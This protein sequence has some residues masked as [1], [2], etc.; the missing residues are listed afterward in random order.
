MQTNDDERDLN[1]ATVFDWITRRWWDKD[2]HKLLDENGG[3]LSFV[4]AA[5]KDEKL[6]KRKMSTQIDVLEDKYLEW[7]ESPIEVFD[8]EDP[9]EFVIYFRHGYGRTMS[10]PTQDVHE[11]EFIL[12]YRVVDGKL[13]HIDEYFN[14]LELFRTLG[15]DLGSVRLMR[16]ESLPEPP[17][18]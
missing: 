1:R 15:S 3:S 12:L 2:Q 17:F 8:T 11:S 9:C 5:E 7:V 6:K 13:Q 10:S 4:F 16:D 18:W 14:P